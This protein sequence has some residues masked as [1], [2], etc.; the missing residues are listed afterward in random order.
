MVFENSEIDTVFD[1]KSWTHVVRSGGC[2]IVVGDPHLKIRTVNSKEGLMMAILAAEAQSRF[3]G[4]G[5]NVR[6]KPAPVGAKAGTPYREWSPIES[7]LSISKDSRPLDY[8]RINRIE[9]SEFPVIYD[10]LDSLMACNYSLE[11][12]AFAYPWIQTFGDIDGA[13]LTTRL[14]ITSYSTA[15]AVHCRFFNRGSPAGF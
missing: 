14:G 13:P 15:L 3:K 4:P 6:S 5:P 8:R 11:G 10:Y 12:F 1:P 7:L 9:Q 2:I